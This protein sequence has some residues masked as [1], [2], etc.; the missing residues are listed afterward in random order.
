MQ[1]INVSR[2]DKKIVKGGTAVA[3]YDESDIR[4]STI[5]NSSKMPD[6]LDVESGDVIIGADI[7][8]GKYNDILGFQS[9]RR[10]NRPQ[11]AAAPPTDSRHPLPPAVNQLPEPS[12]KTTT[13]EMAGR[14]RAA[15]ITTVGTIIISLINTKIPVSEWSQYLGVETL[16]S[17]QAALRDALKGDSQGNTGAASHKIDASSIKTPFELVNTYLAKGLKYGDILVALSI[18][19]ANDIT[20]IPKAI[21]TLDSVIT[22][23]R[24]AAPNA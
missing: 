9:I 11:P 23:K 14:I 18:S 12:S 10:G 16:P 4:F 20:D 2:V 21:K 1:D 17:F 19:N 6:L 15:S 3:V 7:K 22:S 8:A 13:I 5:C 24:G